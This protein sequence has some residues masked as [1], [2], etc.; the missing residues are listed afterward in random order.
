MLTGLTTAS[1][2]VVSTCFD[3]PTLQLAVSSEGPE[4]SGSGEFRLVICLHMIRSR[5]PLY[6]SV[7]W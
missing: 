5:Q 3:H 2:F 7:Q 6:V 4:V 1:R